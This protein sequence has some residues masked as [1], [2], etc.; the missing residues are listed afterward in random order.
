MVRS[1][2][3]TLTLSLT[4]TI[5]SVAG[6]GNS[7]PPACPPCPSSYQCD[8]R[9]GVCVGFRTPLLDAATPDGGHD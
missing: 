6:C 8:P 4:L 5:L 3:L 7:A 2:T 1:K 9:T